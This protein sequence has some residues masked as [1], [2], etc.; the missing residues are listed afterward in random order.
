MLIF[1]TILMKLFDVLIKVGKNSRWL[2]EICAIL[3]TFENDTLVPVVDTSQLFQ[4]T[5]KFQFFLIGKRPIGFFV[6]G[7]KLD[8]CSKVENQGNNSLSCF[9]NNSLFSSRIW[10]QVF[11]THFRHKSRKRNM[12]CCWW[13]R[14]KRQY[15]ICDDD[16]GSFAKKRIIPS[17][18]HF[19]VVSHARRFLGRRN[20]D[21]G[22]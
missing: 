1:L 9:S 3:T 12:R 14:R 17:Y 21:W 15:I 11:E 6:G 13:Q 22:S 5:K 7:W 18:C 4:N 8:H 2:G 19:L 16:F 10:L 20:K